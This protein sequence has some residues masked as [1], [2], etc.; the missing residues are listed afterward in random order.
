MTPDI[1][2]ILRMAW[3]EMRGSWA[4]LAFFFLCVSLGVAAI[5]TLRSVVQHVRTTLTREA[6]AL[7]GADVVL[8][9]Q[10][11]WSPETKGHALYL[12]DGV[13][14]LTE[15]V[16][17]QTMAAPADGRGNGTIRLVEL[18][19]IEAAYPWYG[20]LELESGQYSHALVRDHGVLVSREFLAELGLT[21]GDRV[22]LAG[23]HF[24]IRGVVTRDRVQRSGGFAFGP[25]VYVDLADLRA[26]KLLGF[27]SRATHLILA[28]VRD[29]SVD[30]DRLVRETRTRVRN[31]GIPVRSWRSVEDRLGRN[32]T[33][34]ENYLS[35]VG[36]IVVVLGGIGVWSVARV[37]V[38]QKLRS[39][40]ILKCL[41]A[42]SNTVL[43]IYVLQMMWLAAGGCLL[44]VGLA[45]GAVAA[46]P[47]SILQPLGVASVAIT[48]SAALQGMGVGL[49]VSLLF[50]S[51][52][53]LEVRRVKPLLLLRAHSAPT[54]R[55]RDWR[56]WLAA[57]AI[58]A[59]LALVAVWQ[60]GSLRTGLYVVVGL[61]VVAAVLAGAGR[62]LV[63]LVKPLARSR[64]FALRH[65]VVSL[66]RPGNQTRVILMIVGLGSFFVLAVRALQVNLVSELAVQVS[67]NSPDLVL[68]DVQRDQV[69]AV[70][71]A[72]APHL[73]EPARL[74]PLMRA[75]VAGID[76]AKTKLPTVDDV[77]QHGRL[78]REFGMTYRD[79]LEKNETLV[80]GVFWSGP[81]TTDRTPEGQDTEVSIESLVQEEAGVLVGDV[82][83]FD[84][85]GRVIEARVTSIRDV[86][87]DDT[88]SG[89][90][91]FVLR[92]AP[93][94]AATPQT[95]VGFLQLR[96]DPDA[97]GALQRELVRGYPNV[98][99][100]D[101][102]DVIQAIREVVDNVTLGVTIVGAVTLVGGLLILVGAVAMTKFQ[103]RYEAAIYRTLGAS[104]RR[105]GAMVSI[106]YGLLGLLAGALGAIGALVLSWAA[107]TNLFDIDW[108]P[109]SGLL[110]SGALLTALTVVI[111]GLA[112]SIDVLVS[113]PLGTLRG[114]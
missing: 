53:L 78:T 30:L 58:A 13:S 103:R 67:S 74:L 36:F 45:A 105:L 94:L 109:A 44:G 93:V 51:V 79:A 80:S 81:Q 8:Q 43:A 90:F 22:R 2:F 84:I 24:T 55:V 82:M 92:P 114:E 4:R 65:A 33:V 31:Q 110:A 60:A 97:R 15:V 70:R 112:S 68:I 11:P 41:G 48:L 99:A 61:A 46:I 20:A 16:E 26:T 54:A 59:G 34:A 1:M 9:S 52:P 5:V 42:R 21:V 37:V 102:R 66:G 72:V 73:R 113:K 29:A 32:L 104:T 6:R 96:H 83:R 98:S 87:W 25:R 62:L 63:A 89:G 23:E 28:R 69:D 56:S 57:V 50:A 10:R 76:G 39:V 75:R 12:L 91:V 7:I 27:G 85:G 40:A 108:R 38:Q 17:T 107:A 3:R 14:D 35:L 18:R 88:Q 86:A 19:G 71:Q 47:A 106:E 100:I 95:F 101:V 77:R 64:G 111:V 49:L